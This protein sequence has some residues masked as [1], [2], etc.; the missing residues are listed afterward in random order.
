METETEPYVRLASL[1]ELHKVVAQLNTAR[2]MADT[3]QTIADGAVAALGFELAAVNAVAPDGDLLV[4]AV[5]GSEAAE[6]MLA[7]R[8]G[9]RRTR[10]TIGAFSDQGRRSGSGPVPG[11]RDVHHCGCATQ[12]TSR[13]CGDCREIRDHRTRKNPR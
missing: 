9:S 4:A 13:R 8:R 7:G 6:A 2:S 11:N 12:S 5:A 10:R 1:R 3:L